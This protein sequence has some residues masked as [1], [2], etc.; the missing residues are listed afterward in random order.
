M[1]LLNTMVDMDVTYGVRQLGCAS[2]PSCWCSG[3]ILM[4]IP[5]VLNT[6]IPCIA[7]IFKVSL[8]RPHIFSQNSKVRVHGLHE[9]CNVS[10][11]VI[12]FNCCVVLMLH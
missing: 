8:P 4:C 11:S 12:V 6:F 2:H 3:D 5:L 1:A 7:T 9:F 10:E